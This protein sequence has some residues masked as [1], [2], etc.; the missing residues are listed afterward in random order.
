MNGLPDSLCRSIRRS[1]Q[2][3]KWM[4]TPHQYRNLSFDRRI[5]AIRPVLVTLGV[6]GVVFTVAWLL[7]PPQALYRLLLPVML[8]LVWLARFGWR[9]GLGALIA[10]L[11]RLER[12]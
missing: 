2:R 9:E 4:E 12:S 8:G 10:F 11:H 7:L 5:P 1:P 6:T 3:R